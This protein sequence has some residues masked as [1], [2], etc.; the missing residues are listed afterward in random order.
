MPN[1]QQELLSAVAK[2]DPRV[3]SGLMNFLTLAHHGQ[4]PDV[5]QLTIA[6][7]MR[8]FAAG[9]LDAIER[10]FRNT[11][12]R[13]TSSRCQALRELLQLGLYGGC[14][15]AMQEA[16]GSMRDDVRHELLQIARFL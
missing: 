7:G 9:G 13:V 16:V 5:M 15:Q 1:Q 10:T 8:L 2:E 14:R 12:V 3:G 4:H 6:F 11:A